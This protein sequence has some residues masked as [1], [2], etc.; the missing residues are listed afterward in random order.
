MAQGLI[1]Q[2][3][4]VKQLIDRVDFLLE[5]ARLTEGDEMQSKY[6]DARR[7]PLRPANGCPAARLRKRPA[8]WRTVGGAYVSEMKLRAEIEKGF[9]DG[10]YAVD[11]SSVPFN[12]NQPI[13][14]P[15]ATLWR[16]LTL[17]R[18]ARFGSRDMKVRGPAEKKIEAALKSPTQLEFVDTPLT[19]VIDYLKDYH[20]IEI[21]LDK[22]AMDEAGIG[23][24]IT[25]T[26]N[27][28]GVSLKSALRLMLRELG[29]DVPDPG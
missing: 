7:P 22:K 29:L 13:V 24:D 8:S 26:K 19:D 3:Q 15:D 2:Q 25:V 14:Y 23:T 5:E 18:K 27:L 20:Q 16:E 4:T 28:K 9:M 10:L 11:T 1:R 17:S 12:D 21:Q 6:D